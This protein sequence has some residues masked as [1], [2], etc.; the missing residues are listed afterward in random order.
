MAHLSSLVNRPMIYLSELTAGQG[1]RT[2]IAVS[3]LILIICR[4]I[5]KDHAIL[6]RPEL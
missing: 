2:N 6:L 1:K 5:P 4:H 3:Q